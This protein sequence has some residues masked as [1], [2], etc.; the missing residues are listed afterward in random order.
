MQVKNWIF[1][2][3]AGQK[4]SAPGERSHCCASEGRDGF[5]DDR[6]GRD[7]SSVKSRNEKDNDQ[8]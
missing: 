1:D 2:S 3:G 5:A 7:S 6:A 4:P 8:L